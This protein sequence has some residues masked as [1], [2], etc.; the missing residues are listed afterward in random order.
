MGVYGQADGSAYLE[1]GNSKVRRTRVPVSRIR[2]WI[3]ILLSSC[4]NN[5]KNLE[6]Y[7]FVTLFD[8][9]L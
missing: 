5:K 6:F 2:L 1:Q 8:L 7:Y 4:K 9:F 3:R